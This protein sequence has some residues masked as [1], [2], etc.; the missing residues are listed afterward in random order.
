MFWRFE[1]ILR[2][3]EVETWESQVVWLWRGGDGKG[4]GEK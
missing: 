3:E 2:D 1:K 4:E